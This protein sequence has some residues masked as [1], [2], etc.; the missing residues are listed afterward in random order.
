MKHEAALSS[1]KD[2]EPATNR[3]VAECKL[4]C[5]KL[6]TFS[7]S[8]EI[9]VFYRTQSLIIIFTRFIH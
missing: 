5:R 6:Y 8:Q 9:P 7:L 2:P 3:G 1:L 4:H